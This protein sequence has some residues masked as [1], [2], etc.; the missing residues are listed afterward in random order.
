MIPSH[1]NYV[2]TSGELAIPLGNYLK[3]NGF[4]ARFYEEKSL[5]NVVRYS[6]IKLEDYEL[7]ETTISDWRNS[8]D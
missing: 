3:E 7:L 1:A 6:I 4:L 2:F 8:L 5:E